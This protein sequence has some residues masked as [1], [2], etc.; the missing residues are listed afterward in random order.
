MRI[1]V[2]FGVQQLTPQDVQGRVVAVID[3]LR[4][5]TTIAVALSN[6]ARSIMPME[7]SDDAVMR[8]KQLE[9]GAFRLAGERRMLKMEG[10]DL[11]NSPLEHTREA[12][13]GRTILLAT[14]NG[15][16]ALLAVQGARDVVVA[17]YVNLTAVSTMLRTAVRGGA[18]ITLVCAGQDRQFALEDA[19][20]AGRVVHLVAKRLAGIEFN[21]AALA[22]TMIDKK[23]GTN[24]P[25]LFKT[26]AHGRALAAA[27]FGEDLITCGA[28]D[29]YPVIPIY[30]DRQITKLG[31]ERER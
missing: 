16:K 25:R 28:V 9:R 10:F 1:D 4:A 18:D 13:E 8:S 29:S 26:A 27:G 20:C 22:A 23:Y 30:Q 5:S 21:D 17:S 12:V 14:T 11:G 19:A 31:P 3:V 2:L 15:T 24:L 6:G 7:N